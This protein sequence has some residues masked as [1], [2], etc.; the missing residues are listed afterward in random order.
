VHRINSGVNRYL[1]RQANIFAD[2][3]ASAFVNPVSDESPGADTGDLDLDPNE[4]K[5]F[6]VANNNQQNRMYINLGG[7]SFLDL[8]ANLPWDQ[9]RSYDT[10]LFDV[11]GDGDLDIYWVNQD[12]DRIYINTIIP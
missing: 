12:Q 9:M 7:T 3:T 8:T 5:D 4:Y 10:F 11:D 2:I 1:F 6:I